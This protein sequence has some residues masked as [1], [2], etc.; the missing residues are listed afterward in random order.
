MQAGRNKRREYNFPGPREVSPDH[1]FAWRE[2]SCP[3]RHWSSGQSLSNLRSGTD[4]ESAVVSGQSL[5]KASAREEEQRSWAPSSMRQG[6]VRSLSPLTE[7]WNLPPLRLNAPDC[8]SLCP[9]CCTR[10]PGF[11]IEG[12]E[13][14]VNEMLDSANPQLMSENAHTSSAL[15]RGTNWSGSSGWR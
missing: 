11:D 8:P 1:V 3:R 5:D 14:M 10:R 13:N 2:R 15:Q 4:G 7:Q 9:V 6:D 12:L